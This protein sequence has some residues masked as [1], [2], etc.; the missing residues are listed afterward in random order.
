MTLWK[1]NFERLSFAIITALLVT[2]LLLIFRFFVV[3]LLSIGVL[4]ILIIAWRRSLFEELILSSL[5]DKRG[6]GN[7]D[8]LSR[9]YSKSAISRLE[10]R[11][12]VQVNNDV[13]ELLDKD[14]VFTFDKFKKR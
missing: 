14:Y 12:I 6:Y 4:V 5:K 1:T 2:L 7:Y 11:A 9:A 3:S 13:V 8:K 10:K